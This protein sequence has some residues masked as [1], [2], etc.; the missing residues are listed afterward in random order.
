MKKVVVNAKEFLTDIRACKSDRTLMREYCLSEKSLLHLKNELLAK[1][2]VS[3]K[4][5]KQQSGNI[6][7]RKRITSERFLYDFRQNPDDLYLMEKYGLKPHQ[8]RKV[9]LNLIERNLLTD[10]EY[11][12][13]EGRV[14]AVEEARKPSPIT[15]QQRMPST[16]VS[17]IEQDEKTEPHYAEQNDDAEAQF[18]AQ[19]CDSQLP[20]E[21]FRDHTGIKIGSRSPS[22][23]PDFG[24]SREEERPYGIIGLAGNQTTVVEII[25]SDCCPRCGCRKSPESEDV[26]LSCGIVFA[27]VESTPRIVAGAVWG[28][29]IPKS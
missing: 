12:S 27:K 14:P 24:A 26:C 28:D 16:V 15:E 17:V 20:P 3:L 23:L 6:R 1:N 7:T 25:D 21:F 2:L 22:E 18:I 8:L 29:D 11:E 9:Y 13:R 4:E 19:H 5:L 10:L